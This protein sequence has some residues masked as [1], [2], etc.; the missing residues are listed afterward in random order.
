MSSEVK[1]IVPR[2]IRIVRKSTDNTDIKICTDAAVVKKPQ[3]DVIPHRPIKNL[4]TK[5]QFNPQWKPKAKPNFNKANGQNNTKPKPKQK[6]KVGSINKQFSLEN[7]PD[8][9]MYR[10]S[11]IFGS[12]VVC[13][14]FVVDGPFL[15]SVV[16]FRNK[17]STSYQDLC[18]ILNNLVVADM[19]PRL[20]LK[21]LEHTHEGI[22]NGKNT[23]IVHRITKDM[24]TPKD[25]GNNLVFPSVISYGIIPGT[26]VRNV[27][28]RV[29]IRFNYVYNPNFEPKKKK[30]KS[31]KPKQP[32]Q[33]KTTKKVVKAK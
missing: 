32:K 8:R 18:R 16:E 24:Y 13:D 9:R 29:I 21:E 30:E 4:Q 3:P 7:I 28:K 33:V 20:W 17:L 11:I 19:L 10:I 15:T 23:D 25:D 6:V 1:K 27:S 5:P 14:T 31:V 26:P 12:S 22:L 2:S